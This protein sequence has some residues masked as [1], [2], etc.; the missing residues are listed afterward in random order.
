MTFSSWE[1]VDEYGVDVNMSS[2]PK[3]GKDQQVVYF[4]ETMNFVVLP[5]QGNT[6]LRCAVLRQI[7][8]VP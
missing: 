7:V 8:P 6:L 5:N 4:L 1:A 3:C 2:R